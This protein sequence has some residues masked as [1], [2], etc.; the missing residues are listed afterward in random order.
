MPITN[1]RAYNKHLIKTVL[2]LIISPYISIVSLMLMLLRLPA[3]VPNF[4]LIF[5]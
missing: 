1:A 3:E 5:F 4:M 2:L